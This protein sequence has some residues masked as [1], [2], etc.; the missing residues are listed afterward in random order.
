MGCCSTGQEVMGP[1]SAILVSLLAGVCFGGGG[2][3]IK[4]AWGMWGHT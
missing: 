1:A 2:L 4:A 3:G